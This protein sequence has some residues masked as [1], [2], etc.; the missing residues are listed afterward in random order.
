VKTWAE[1]KLAPF[2][3]NFEHILKQIT[4]KPKKILNV[5]KPEVFPNDVT[6]L[7]LEYQNTNF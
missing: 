5:L 7:S 1:S 6:D 2:F 4:T 3:L